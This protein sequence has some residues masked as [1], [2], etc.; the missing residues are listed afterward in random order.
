MDR[1]SRLRLHGLTSRR[2]VKSAAIA[3]PEEAIKKLHKAQD[4]D[5]WDRLSTFA[6]AIPLAASGWW[7]FNEPLPNDGLS[8]SSLGQALSELGQSIREAAYIRDTVYPNAEQLYERP[9]PEDWKWFADSLGERLERIE[10]IKRSITPRSFRSPEIG[11]TTA[12]MALGTLAALLV[13]RIAAWNRSARL[14]RL[15]DE[16]K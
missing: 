5:I 2:S 9:R 4:P 3:N 11:A 14:R 12:A 1:L 8:S 10:K 7:A 16:L 15:V 6:S 13:N